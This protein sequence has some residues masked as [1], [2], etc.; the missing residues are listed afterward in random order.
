MNFLGWFG[1]WIGKDGWRLEMLTCKKRRLEE[2]WKR[3]VGEEVRKENG[4]GVGREGGG[5]QRQ[6][7]QYEPGKGAGHP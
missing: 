3:R 4:G 6:R 5:R 7:R 1:M 2:R